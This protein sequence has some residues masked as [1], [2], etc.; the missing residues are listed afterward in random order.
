MRSADSLAPA[1]IL[2]VDRGTTGTRTLVFD[3]E[4]ELVGRAAREFTRAG[5]AELAWV[6]ISAWTLDRVRSLKR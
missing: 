3:L 1:V 2:A 6:G 5:R 4:G